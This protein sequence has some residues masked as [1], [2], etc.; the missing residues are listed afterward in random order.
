MARCPLLFSLGTWTRAPLLWLA[1]LQARPATARTPPPMALI[2]SSLSL[3]SMASSR[4]PSLSSSWRELPAPCSTA[5][6]GQRCPSSTFGRR[7]VQRP[8]PLGQAAVA[9]KLPAPSFSSREQQP[10][11]LRSTRCFVLRSEQHAGMPVRCLL[12]CAVPT[13]SSFTLVR[14]RRSLFDSASVLFSYD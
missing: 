8:S 2:S 12:F 10:R 14:P 9:S 4:A 1:S 6:R 3:L 7:P 5:S 13:S 11:R